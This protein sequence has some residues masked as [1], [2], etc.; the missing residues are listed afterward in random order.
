M[1]KM[2]TKEWGAEHIFANDLYCFKEMRLTTGVLCSY[3][4][5]EKKDESFYLPDTTMPIYMKMEGIEFL[6]NP[7]NFI[8]IPPGYKHQFCAIMHSDTWFY[9]VSTNDDPADSFRD[10]VSASIPKEQYSKWWTLPDFDSMIGSSFSIHGD[11]AFPNHKG[12]M[13]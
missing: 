8:H 6:L 3:H 13:S 7:N 1:I 4:Y 2:V 5:H 11:P 9:E 12:I 10:T